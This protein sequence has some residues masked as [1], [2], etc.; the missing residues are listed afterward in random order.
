MAP[1]ALL[2]TSAIQNGAFTTAKKVNTTVASSSS[3]LRAYSQFNNTP[4]T[5]TE[6]RS[7]S[8]DGKPVL[9]IAD[10]LKDDEKLRAL[11]TLV[12][13]RAV[14]FFRGGEITPTEQRTLVDKLGKLSGKPNTSTLHVHPLTSA[15]QDFGDEISVI[16]NHFDFHKDAKRTGDNILRLTPG[17]VLSRPLQ[18]KLWHSDIT[19]E[20]VPSDYACLAIRTFPEQGG[21]DTV[22]ASAYEAY[23]RLSPAYQR[24]L[25]GLTATHRGQHFIDIARQYNLQFRQE[26]GSPDN[27]GD[28]LEAIHPVIRTNPVTGW[29]GLF[30]NKEFTKRIN[31]LTP[32]ESD[33]ILEYLFEHVSAN[34]DL[35]VRFRWE[36]DN[37]A[38]WDNR[39]SFHAATYD[40]DGFTR[41]GTRAVSIG[42]RPYFDPNSVSRRAALKAAG[43]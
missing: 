7:V 31:E 30:V 39:S 33:A 13:E 43:Q 19:F 32:D 5:G 38:I 2:E 28:T 25:E 1:A 12:S 24:F 16:S 4:A 15:G 3:P 37:L 23:D 17:D 6:F 34:H 20:P 21:G 22:W 14:V 35:Q 42:E 27:R 40:L 36:K 26:R 10:V 18:K 8:S 41:E 29:K 9:T 11:A